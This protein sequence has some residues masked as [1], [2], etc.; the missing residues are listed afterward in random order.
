MIYSPFLLFHSGLDASLA[1]L[2]LF[3]LSSF[4]GWLAGATAF[5]LHDNKQRVW[6][7]LNAPKR[8]FLYIVGSL[9]AL[10]SLPLFFV[11]L[12]LAHSSWC[13]Y[14]SKR[15]RKEKMMGII[16]TIESLRTNNKFALLRENQT[17]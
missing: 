12:P 11:S 6:R 17:T 13:W 8:Y 3:A 15:T 16:K 4:S 5:Y 2:F 14:Q 7:T 10:L 1:L 9:V